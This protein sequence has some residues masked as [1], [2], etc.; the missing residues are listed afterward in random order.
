[1]V[2]RKSDCVIRKIY[3]GDKNVPADTATKKY[4]RAGSRQECLQRGFGIADA[5][6]RLK[7]LRPNSL[8]NIVY[9]GDTYDQNF[10]KK[11]IRTLAG[12][13]TKM[14]SLG[15]NQKLDFL[16]KILIK[17]NKVVDQKAINSVIMWLHSKGVGNLPGC[18]IVKE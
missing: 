12:L 14:K 18:K 2:F 6:N 3:C 1:M 7:R 10:R 15:A 4:S 5:Q 9:I 17:K 11:G 13:Q 8:Q 16:R